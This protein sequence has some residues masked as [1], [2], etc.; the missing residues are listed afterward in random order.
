MRLARI[1]YP[2]EEFHTCPMT[3]FPGRF[4]ERGACHHHFHVCMLSLPARVVTPHTILEIGRPSSHFCLRPIVP[5]LLYFRALDGLLL[6][7]PLRL[8]VGKVFMRMWSRACVRMREGSEA[9][10]ARGGLAFP[11]PLEAF[12]W[13][14]Q[15]SFQNRVFADPP[16]PGLY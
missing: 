15:P 5:F 16:P 1:Y 4:R 10:L 12:R 14:R 8:V 7:T 9:T 13:P 6:R 11:K 2:T 3:E